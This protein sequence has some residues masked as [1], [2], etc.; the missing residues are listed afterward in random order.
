MRSS[1]K[2]LKHLG[3]GLGASSASDQRPPSVVVFA[4]ICV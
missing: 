1:I 2:L 4:R 3:D